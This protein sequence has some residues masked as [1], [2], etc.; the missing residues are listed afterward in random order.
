M[1]KEAKRPTDFFVK[2]IDYLRDIC[3]N[4]VY[5]NE[6]ATKCSCRQPDIEGDNILQVLQVFQS[7]LRRQPDIEGDN[8]RQVSCVNPHYWVPPIFICRQPDIEGDNEL[9]LRQ[10]FV[11]L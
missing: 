9:H 7:K 1:Q 8:S 11:S 5:V 6:K 2:N 10:S 3:H 4:V